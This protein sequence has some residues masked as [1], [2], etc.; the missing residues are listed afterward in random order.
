MALFSLSNSGPGR[1]GFR[2]APVER[3]LCLFSLRCFRTLGSPW[4]V[5][6]TGPG[7]PLTFFASPKKVSKERRPRCRCPSGSRNGGDRNGKRDKLACGSDKSR[8]FIRFSPR[9]FGSV[10]RGFNSKT[11][12]PPHPGPPLAGREFS[13]AWPMPSIPHAKS[14]VVMIARQAPVEPKRLWPLKFRCEQPKKGGAKRIKKRNL[15]EPQA[16]LFRFPLCPSLLR[17][18]RRGCEPRPPFF[19]YFLWRSKES[20]WPAGASPGYSLRRTQGS[21]APKRKQPKHPGPLIRRMQDATRKFYRQLEKPSV[22]TPALLE[23]APRTEHPSRRTPENVAALRGA[24][25][26]PM[27]E[28]QPI[29]AGRD[30]QRH[31]CVAQHLPARTV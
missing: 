17:V 20:E 7:G 26:Q 13:R 15:S 22:S 21:E 11:S 10:R 16:S 9:H 23:R 28:P 18:P 27:T 29:A 2:M 1:F 19:A 25:I 24:L 3:L 12:T 6:G 4:G 31:S 14:A 5:A 30:L 8:F